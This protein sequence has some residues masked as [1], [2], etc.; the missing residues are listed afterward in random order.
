MTLIEDDR[1][2]KKT[3]HEI[4][5]ELSMLSVAELQ[6]RIGLL[7]AEIERLKAEVASK[8]KSRSAAESLFKS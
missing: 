8:E 1:L 7:Q 6:A 4:G 3:A 2:P 5:A